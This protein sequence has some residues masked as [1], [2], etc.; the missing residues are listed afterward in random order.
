MPTLLELSSLPMPEGLQGQSLFPLLQAEGTTRWRAR[1]AFSE[2][3]PGSDAAVRTES[4]AIVWEGFKLVRTIDPSEG[5]PEIELY[6]H[7]KDPLNLEN[8]ADQKPEVVEKLG[9][10]LE[11]WQRF[12]QSAR[13]PTD[14]EAA[15]GMSSE[16][17]ERLRSL[18]YVQ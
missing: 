7:V 14:G 4:I 6:D 3:R 1:P 11:D 17:L 12:A 5:Q 18:G 9:K 13:L 8:I 10:L 16:Q 2:R 15:S